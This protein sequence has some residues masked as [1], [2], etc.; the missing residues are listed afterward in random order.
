[1]S[2]LVARGKRSSTRQTAAALAPVGLAALAASL[3]V[4]RPFGWAS[5]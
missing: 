4:Y 3:F 1:M 2:H 5:H